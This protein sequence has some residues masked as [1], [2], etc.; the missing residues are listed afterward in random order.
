[1]HR[2]SLLPIAVVAAVLCV[3]NVYADNWGPALVAPTIGTV[4]DDD[5]VP[6][7]MDR[8]VAARRLPTNVGQPVGY[9]MPPRPPRG[10]VIPQDFLDEES[11]PP[12]ITPSKTLK[13][14]PQP[15]A[16]G[17]ETVVQEGEIFYEDDIV[18]PGS[19]RQFATSMSWAEN[20]DAEFSGV[21]AECIPS[22]NYGYT[23]CP[24]V[25]PFGTGITDNLTFFG[26]MTGFRNELDFPEKGNFGMMEGV[27]WAGPVMPLTAISAQVGFRAV[28]SNLYGSTINDAFA[29]RKSIRCQY[30]LTTGLFKRDLGSTMQAGA[31]YDWCFDEFYDKITLQQIRV[32]A[33]LRTFS[34]LEYGFQGAFGTTKEKGAWISWRANGDTASHYRAQNCYF[35]FGRKHFY[36]GNLAELRLG[37]TDEGDIIVGGLGEFPLND[38]LSFNGSFSLL[39]PKE[40]NSGRGLNRETWEVSVGMIFYF[41]GGAGFKPCNP[42]RPMFDVAGNGTF[43][44]RLYR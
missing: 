3:L 7:T 33:S 24:I 44:G 10:T 23:T 5:Y 41:R 38:R 1:M 40:G 21:Y 42:C 32:E 34:N 9:D 36:N 17:N 20:D 12:S 39:S 25:K 35:L 26:G 22:M 14:P 4:A 13:K 15:L 8:R 6:N 37:V 28:Q 2:F 31:V 18:L 30:F 11:V 43:F 16:D 27:N 19:Q 29:Y